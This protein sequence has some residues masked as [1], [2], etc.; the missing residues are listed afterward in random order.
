MSARESGGGRQYP[1]VYASD[2]RGER[3]VHLYQGGFYALADIP[4]NFSLGTVEEPRKESE[5][6]LVLDRSDLRQLK[7]AAD[8]LSFDYEEPFIEMCLEMCRF[9]QNVPGETVRFTANF[10]A[11]RDYR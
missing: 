6:V 3:L 11:D 2:G 5:S 1:G 9:A 7:T 10:V 4:D 8:G